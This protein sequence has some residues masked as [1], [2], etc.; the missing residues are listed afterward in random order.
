[1]RCAET[2]KRL[3]DLHDEGGRPSGEV[4]AHLA[5]CAACREFRLFLEGIGGRVRATL[6]GAAAGLPRPDYAAIRVCAEFERR[7]RE[8][9]RASRTR[10][11]FA[12]AAAVL[13]AGIGIAVGVRAWIGRRDL[14]RMAASVDGF[15]EELFAEPLLADAGFPLE[16]EGGGLRDWLEGS[17]TALL[18]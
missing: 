14:A 3:Q 6:D 9:L 8:A 13:V 17:A 10:L 7:R 12:S 5:G 1:M 2:R 16:G 4:A 11:A 18:P 15:V